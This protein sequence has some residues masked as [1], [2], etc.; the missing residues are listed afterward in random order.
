MPGI[1]IVKLIGKG[2]AESQLHTNKGYLKGHHSNLF[3]LA[4]DVRLGGV[5]VCVCVCARS[6]VNFCVIL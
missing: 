5:C 2:K 6:S 3:L 1:T 4:T